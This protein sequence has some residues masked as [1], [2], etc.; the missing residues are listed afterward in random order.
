M[1][2]APP[3]VPSSADCVTLPNISHYQSAYNLYE[4]KCMNMIGDKS[5][6]LDRLAISELKSLFRFVH[7]GNQTNE[8]TEFSLNL[9]KLMTYEDL[10]LLRFN[11][12][13]GLGTTPRILLRLEFQ[14]NSFVS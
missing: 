11:V 2:M 3:L 1:H 9:A 10:D 14:F 5:K 8:I 13:F 12:D 4:Y 7:G 6:R